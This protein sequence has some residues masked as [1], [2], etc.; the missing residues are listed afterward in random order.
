MADNKTKTVT[1]ILK[2][3]KKE[4][5]ANIMKYAYSYC[6]NTGQCPIRYAH[7]EITEK[8]N[9]RCIMCSAEKIITRSNVMEFKL[10]KKIIDEVCSC[11]LKRLTIGAI[12]EPTTN[13]D[14]AKMLKYVQQK[15]INTELITNLSLPLNKELIDAIAN[16]DELTVSIDGA[17]KEVYEKIWWDVKMD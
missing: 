7:I 1:S 2:N 16:L 15:K 12:G 9:L 10:F 4:H 13:K 5:P 17:T 3:I 11:G 8:C 6:T 14:L